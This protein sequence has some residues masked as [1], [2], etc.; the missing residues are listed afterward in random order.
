M[1]ISPS[2]FGAVP[3]S[4]NQQ[5]VIEMLAERPNDSTLISPAKTP[6]QLCGYYNAVGDYVE[7]YI[8]AASGIRY[9]RIG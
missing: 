7:L 2:H 5:V 1:S 4:Q 9:L 3:V 6:M 8:V